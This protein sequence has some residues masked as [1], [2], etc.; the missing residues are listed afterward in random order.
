[1]REYIVEYESDYDRGTK[2][3]IRFITDNPPLDYYRAIIM[4][5]DHSF[6]S[7]FEI[8]KVV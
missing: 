5:G 2:R 1:M 8:K 6:V 3:Y 7:I 4:Q